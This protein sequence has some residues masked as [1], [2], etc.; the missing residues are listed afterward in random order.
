MDFSDCP[1]YP[2]QGG[3]STRR[4]YEYIILVMISNTWILSCTGSLILGF[5]NYPDHCRHG[6]LPFKEKFLLDVQDSGHP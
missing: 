1:P 6:N 3:T 4:S 2:G 5:T